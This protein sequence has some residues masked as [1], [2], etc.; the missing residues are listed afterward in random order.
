MHP[1]ARGF[2]Q[3]GQAGAAE[4]EVGDERGLLACWRGAGGGLEYN[5]GDAA[6]EFGEPWLILGIAL[7]IH[8]AG[9]QRLLDAASGDGL[10]SFGNA[11]VEPRHARGTEAGPKRDVVETREIAEHLAW[12]MGSR[13]GASTGRAFG[14][15]DDGEQLGCA[16]AE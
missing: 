6:G 15:E 3:T 1:S 10:G 14:G 8:D 4:E 16:G 13:W 11:F 5:E 7:A 9:H 2:V 12:S